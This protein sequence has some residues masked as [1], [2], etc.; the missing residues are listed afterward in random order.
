MIAFCTA[1]T[2]QLHKYVV[3]ALYN[4]SKMRPSQKPA[5]KKLLK[6]WKIFEAS[7][8]KKEMSCLEFPSYQEIADRVCVEMEGWVCEHEKKRKV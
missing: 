3:D 2:E 1:I 5:S 7:I 6:A 4:A 8:D